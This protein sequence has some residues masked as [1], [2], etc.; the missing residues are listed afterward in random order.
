M[1]IDTELSEYMHL[2]GLLIREPAVVGSGGS[3]YR[4]KL[5]RER[6]MSYGRTELGRLSAA[7]GG[8]LTGTTLQIP[9][10]GYHTTGETA[11][12]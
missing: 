4:V 8:E 2:L 11:F 10:K 3:F 7:P 6:P 5:T 12:I 9:T 1:N